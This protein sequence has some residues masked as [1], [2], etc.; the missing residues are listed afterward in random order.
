MDSSDSNCLASV[1]FLDLLNEVLLRNGR[2]PLPD[3]SPQWST[4][5]VLDQDRVLQ[6]LAGPG[7]GKTEV[8][9]WRVLYELF[10]NQAPPAFLLVTTFTRKAGTELEVRL[11][12]RADD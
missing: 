12:E 2:L 5:Q 8:L 10:V 4:I 6:I 11:V 1:D 9:V 7:S 3:T